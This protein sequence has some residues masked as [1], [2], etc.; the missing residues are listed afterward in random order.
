[1]EDTNDSHEGEKEYSGEVASIRGSVVDIRF[2]D[3]LP[4]MNSL[5]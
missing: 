1:M 4:P 2:Q 5:I 3:R